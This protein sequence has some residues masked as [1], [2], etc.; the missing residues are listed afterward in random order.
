MAAL[1]WTAACSVLP[2]QDYPPSD[3]REV[4]VHYDLSTVRPA[5]VRVPASGPD[6]TVLWMDT[7]PQGL[8]E[9]FKRGVRRLHIDA[10][11][12]VIRCRYRAYERPAPEA[13][14]REVPAPEDLFPGA[15]SIETVW[16]RDG[17]S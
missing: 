12:L 4:I 3:E 17:D 10:E 2:R 1:L 9:S 14:Q 8:R 7:E 5:T 6:L 15:I 16:R 11:Q 13:G